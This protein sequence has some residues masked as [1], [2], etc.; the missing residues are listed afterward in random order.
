MRGANEAKRSGSGVWR[1]SG[2]GQR[3]TQPAVGRGES[4]RKR[5]TRPQRSLFKRRKDLQELRRVAWGVG[6]CRSRGRAPFLT[7]G[8]PQ[9]RAKGCGTG[10]KGRAATPLGVGQPSVRLES[11]GDVSADSYAEAEP[12][13]KGSGAGAEAGRSHAAGVM[14]TAEEKFS[15][16]GVLVFVFPLA[17]EFLQAVS[18]DARKLTRERQWGN[19]VLPCFAA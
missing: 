9:R 10:V 19:Q 13:D 14:S 16:D 4:G 1:D 17:W 6:S 5:S 2:N 3:P 8:W 18:G 15:C 7:L 11:G 12:G